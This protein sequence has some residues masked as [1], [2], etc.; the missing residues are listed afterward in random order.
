MKYNYSKKSIWKWI[1]IYLIAG[2]LVYGSVY[3][4]F[5]HK[6]NIQESS[7]SINQYE[8]GYQNID[9]KNWKT[10]QDTE[11]GFSFKYPSQDVISWGG[12]D[13]MENHVLMTL[14]PDGSDKGLT[15]SLNKTDTFSGD[16]LH[17]ATFGDLT[18]SSIVTVGSKLA[19]Q[20]EIAQAG[21]KGILVAIPVKNNAIVEVSLDNCGAG[22]TGKPVSNGEAGFLNFILSTFTFE[23]PIIINNVSGPTV[24]TI[25]Q[26]GTW[27]IDATDSEGN[28]LIYGA[29]WGDE[30]I[31][32]G[33]PLNLIKSQN[34]TISHTYQN[35]LNYTVTFVVKDD[36]GNFATKDIDINVKTSV[37]AAL[38]IL[39][40][41]GEETWHIGETHTITWVAI[42]LKNV[43]IY[44]AYYPNQQDQN[45][46]ATERVAYMPASQG[47]YSWTIKNPI[48][49]DGAD[50][51]NP[52]G[53]V[54]KI[55]IQEEGGSTKDFSKFFNITK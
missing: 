6:G 20:Y 40:P 44:L 42:G 46:M 18:H 25:G 34:S 53:Q 45:F 2:V 23:N 21:C 32:D 37:N 10:Y 4:A 35:S 11:H 39:S 14:V 3:F 51:L 47:S 19:Y 33:L 38:H 30:G 16:V 27:T 54:F 1:S 55:Y 49:S 13:V 52:Q 26:T 28:K 43:Y 41:N 17:Q 36:K 50:I 29:I 9:T 22:S 31:G 7:Y 24:I 8:W 5:F 48:S 12:S 15:I